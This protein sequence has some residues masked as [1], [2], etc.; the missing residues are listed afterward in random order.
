MWPLPQEVLHSDH[1]DHSVSSQSMAA[2][3][4]KRDTKSTRSEHE[5]KNHTGVPEESLHP[6]DV[7]RKSVV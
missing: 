4:K 5:V 3:N 2:E 6:K 1:W 7:D